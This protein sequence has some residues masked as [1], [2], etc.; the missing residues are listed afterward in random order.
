MDTQSLKAFLLVAENASFSAA[1]EALHLTQ[2]A[3]SKRIAALESQLDAPLFNRIGRQVSLTEAGSALL[4]HAQAIAAHLDQARQSIDDLSG[5]V[6]GRLRLGTSHHVGLHR[7][8]PVLRN[9]SEAYPAV[10]LDIEFMD[11]EQAFEEIMRG[12]VELAVVTLPP[13]PDSALVTRPVWQ[14]ALD[15]MAA[16]DH[17]LADHKNLTLRELCNYPVVLPGLNTFTGRIVREI[18]ERE[19]LRLDITLSTNYLETIRMMASVGLGWTLLPRTMLQPPLK[20]LA[21]PGVEPARSLGLMYHRSR[22][23]SNAAEAFIRLLP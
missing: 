12:R 5:A 19:S 10:S 15:F 20:S 2:P 1:A 16:G 7:L 6:S 8:P 9:Y 21:V 14:D 11:S 23:L 4:P 13:A 3:V 22:R 18:F 17:P